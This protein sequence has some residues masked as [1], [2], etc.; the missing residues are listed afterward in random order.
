MKK[1]LYKN[2]VSEI[3]DFY[4]NM[5]NY[6]RN[7][8][9]PKFKRDEKDGIYTNGMKNFHYSTFELFKDRLFIDFYFNE[10]NDEG[11]VMFQADVVHLGGKETRT[12]EYYTLEEL[13]KE[14]NKIT[15]EEKLKLVFVNK[16]N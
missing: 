3:E 6:I 8:F 7:E 4:D 12:K 14:I 16:N 9:I 11:F 13:Y 10:Y 2:F 15:L 5:N 1:T